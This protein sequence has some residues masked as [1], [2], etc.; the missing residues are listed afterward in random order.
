MFGVVCLWLQ[1]SF[2]AFHPGVVIL[3]FLFFKKPL[4]MPAKRLLMRKIRH[5]LE[6]RFAA[7]LSKRAIARS[8]GIG[9]S[10]VSRVLERAVMAQ[11]T[12]PLPDDMTDAKLAA[13]IYPNTARAAAGSRPVPDWAEVHLDLA[14]NRSLTLS[15]VWKEYIEKHPNGLQYSRFAELYRAWRKCEVDQVMRQSHKAGERLFVDYSGKKPCYTDPITGEVHTPELFVAVPGASNYLY[16]E[17]TPS[18]K[19]ADFCRSIR[20]T[21]EFL[22][23]LPQIV[24][25]DNLKAAVIKVRKD[26]VPILN[27]SFEDLAAHYRVNIL[28]AR[29][30]R[31]KDKSKAESGVLL[32]QRQI[33][34]VLRNIKFFSL[35]ELNAAIAERVR[36]INSTPFQKLPGSR[37]SMFE[38]VDKPA[39]R[40]L[41][42]VPYV[43][44]EW[45]G[46]RKVAMDYHVQIEKHYYSVPYKFIGRTVRGLIREHTVEIFHDDTRIASHRRGRISG[47]HTTL[48]EH[49]PARHRKASDWSKERFIKWARKAGPDTAKL[50]KA[51]FDRYDIQ[52]Q[53]YRRCMAIL[54]LGRKYGYEN[55][56]QACGI[57]LKNCTLDSHAMRRIIMD[58]LADQ[59][60][61]PKTA[62]EHDNI[63]G[64]DYYS[65]NGTS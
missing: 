28:P 61:A 41:P 33:L 13:I 18:Q 1:V 54:Q 63:R 27:K 52:E 24:V 39:L 35:E 34:A 64:A 57:A 43:Y 58:I 20:R 65:S 44:G 55:L 15:Q 38:A 42:M 32:A 14:K 50:I 16:A 9:R 10:S 17:A 31:P 47:R 37:Q 60:Y 4:P 5:I 59:Q 7:K 22:G 23:G 36:V 46:K 62:I 2:L 19:T 30:R 53:A 49:M 40:P 12:W 51:N 6:L 11:L 48:R 45:T 8:L 25:P 29:P 3:R 56:E 26:D 21:F